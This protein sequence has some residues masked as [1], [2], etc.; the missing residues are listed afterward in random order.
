MKNLQLLC[1]Q[2]QRLNSQLSTS[3]CLC[4]IQWNVGIQYNWVKMYY[5]IYKLHQTHL[6]SCKRDHIT[7][8]FEFYNH[9]LVISRFFFCY[10][11]LL[12]SHSL[13]IEILY[14]VRPS[15]NFF[16]ELTR[17]TTF[18]LCLHWLYFLIICCAIDST[19]ICVKIITITTFF[20][21]CFLS[22][23]LTLLKP[24]MQKS[25]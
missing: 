11:S 4:F 17:W 22:F 18:A 9:K 7:D 1:G 24:N 14:V 10:V 6:A 8:E 23:L 16:K 12:K 19:V 21:S 2:K 25:M 13:S 20:C 15:L 5:T 3:R